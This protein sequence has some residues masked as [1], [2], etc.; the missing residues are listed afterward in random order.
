MTSRNIISYFNDIQ[1]EKR[2]LSS[3]W[4][5]I[6]NEKSY[7]DYKHQSYLS[8]IL[9]LLPLFLISVIHL[10]IT[11]NGYYIGHLFLTISYLLSICFFIL[12]FYNSYTIFVLFVFFS[13]IISLCLHEF[14]HALVAYKY[15]DITMVYKG[16]LYL[17]ILN[18]LDIFHTLVIPLVTLFITGFGIPGN[19]YWLQLHFIR[20]RFQ[21]SFIFLSGPISDILYILLFVFFYNM[22]TFFKKNK[23]FNVKPHP[24]LF[25]SLATSISFLVESFLLNI[26]PIL[27]FDGWGIIEPYLPYFLNDLINE[28]IVYNFLSYICPLLVFIYFNFIETKFLFFTKITNYIL[29]DLFGIAIY[30]AAYGANSFPTLYSYLKK[31]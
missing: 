9:S 3:N 29:Q 28:E 17:D 19:L 20:S 6:H 1:T 15:G 22:Y 30:H 2:H 27:G 14:S 31:L 11:M 21:L 24:A 26:C 23:K 8:F 5:L 13:F 10:S 18:Y 12:Y 25:V 7:E 16:Y 4:L